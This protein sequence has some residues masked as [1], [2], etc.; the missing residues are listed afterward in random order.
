[1][2]KKHDQ[3]KRA[4]DGLDALARFHFKLAERIMMRNTLPPPACNDT[5]RVFSLAMAVQSELSNG[6]QPV[7]T[8]LA[9]LPRLW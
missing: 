6:L 4:N 2:I 7:A 9:A 1:M 5:L 3:P 8:G